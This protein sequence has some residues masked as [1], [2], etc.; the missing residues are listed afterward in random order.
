MDE[1]PHIVRNRDCEPRVDA[2]VRRTRNQLIGAMFALVREHGYLGFTVAEMLK[3]AGVARSTFYTHY[4]GKDDLLLQSFEG[5]LRMLDCDPN[6]AAPRP[7]PVRELFAHVAEA[8]SFHQALGRAHRLERLYA[9]GI[10]VVTSIVAERQPADTPEEAALQA[11]MFAGALF[12]LLAWWV[13]AGRQ[14]EPAEMER[15]LLEAFPGL[16]GRPA[17]P[18]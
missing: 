10:E 5:M 15:R 6:G 4:R 1:P 3:R 7:F 14:E 9:R 18:V 11:R 13:N 17:T 12:S 8:L 2:R 16:V